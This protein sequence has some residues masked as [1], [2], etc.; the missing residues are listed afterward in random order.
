MLTEGHGALR[1]IAGSIRAWCSRACGGNS[2]SK[3][4]LKRIRFWRATG[5]L[6]D[7]VKLWLGHANE[8]ITDRYAQQ[9]R[10]DVDLRQHWATKVGLGFQ[11]PAPI[12]AT[13]Q[14]AAE[15]VSEEVA[16]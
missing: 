2:E 15:N 1:R 14:L 13:V 11:L 6:E 16:A 7:L 3:L 5:V 9:L 8:T 10:Q 4:F 12:C